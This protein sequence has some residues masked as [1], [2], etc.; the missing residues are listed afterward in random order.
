MKR[1]LP[2]AG[3]LLLAAPNADAAGPTYLNGPMPLL[4]TPAAPA[5]SAYTP[6]PVPN[7]DALAPRAEPPKPGE[8]R[9]AASFNAPS[10]QIRS[11]N[12]YTQGSSFSG[13][14]ERRSRGL[15]SAMAPSLGVIVNQ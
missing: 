12:G 10:P 11:G 15:G 9:L 6:A 14:V 3:L 1:M 4:G 2:L 5:K 13:D 7:P 8:P